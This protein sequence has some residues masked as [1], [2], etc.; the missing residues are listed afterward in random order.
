MLQPKRLAGLFGA[1]PSV[2]LATLSLTVMS[3]GKL[4]A[5]QEARSMMGGAIAFLVYAV[6]VTQALFRL[7]A[8]AQLSTYVLLAAWFGVAFALWAVWLRYSS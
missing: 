1:A 2:A 3:E 7:K 6:A 4:Y 8:P 5:A